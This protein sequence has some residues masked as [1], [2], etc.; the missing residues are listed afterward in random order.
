M[1]KY[2]GEDYLLGL[3]LLYTGMRRGEL[4]AL[5]WQD[6]DL[7]SGVIHVTKKLNYAGHNKPVLENHLKSKNALR[8]VPLLAAS[9]EALPREQMI[10]NTCTQENGD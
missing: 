9:R 7:K 6:I 3:F 10:G 2:R 5:T 1:E 8:D 4:L